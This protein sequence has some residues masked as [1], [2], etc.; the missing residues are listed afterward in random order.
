VG[1]DSDYEWD[2]ARTPIHVGDPRLNRMLLH[3][4]SKCASLNEY[5][6]ACGMPTNQVAT[7]LD[8]F[9]DSEAIG[10]DFFADEVFVN[11]AP[12][13][14]PAPDGTVDIPPNLWE[15]LRVRVGVDTAYTLWKLLRSLER[16]GWVVEHRLHRIMFGL[17]SVA[18]PPYLGVKAGAIWVPLMIFPSPDALIRSGGLLD[19]Y[20][21][22]GSSAI[23]V[24][25]DEQEL[26]S[27]VT[28]VRMWALSK[29]E[30]PVLSVLVLEAPRYN[31]T[32]LT[33]RDA[34]ITPVAVTRDALGNYFL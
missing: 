11:T 17:A 9:L 12:H 31:P 5:A 8:E 28:A 25:C 26:D 21:R 15:Q 6:Q 14:R 34:A 16:S 33:P 29:R 10:L 23:G 22:A 13:G 3:E 2:L 4:P 24:V 27:M 30:P 32:L 7:L 1:F 18:D 19:Q 20:E